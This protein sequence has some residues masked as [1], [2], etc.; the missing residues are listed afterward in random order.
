[1]AALLIKAAAVPFHFWQPDFHTV[2]PTPVSAMLSGIV[3]KLG[4]YGLVRVMT[5]LM[6]PLAGKL[7]P[8]MLWLGIAGIAYGSLG[9]IGTHNLK[10]VLAYSTL[11]QVGFVMVGMGLGSAAAL[12]AAIVFSFNHALAKS[13][14]LML[15]GNV[16][17]RAPI[18]SASF[19]VVTGVGRAVP[20]GG[21]LF[22]IGAMALVGMPPTN[23]FVSKLLLLVSA[24]QHPWL[25]AGLVLLSVLTMIYLFRAYARVWWEP[26]P[27]D[28]KTKPSGDSLLAPTGLIACCLLLGLLPGPLTQLSSRTSAYL[29]EP[30]TYINAVHEFTRAGPRPPHPPPPTGTLPPPIASTLSRDNTP[31]GNP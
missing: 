24:G 6:V 23:G 27:D 1:V 2:S 29:Q 15:A 14:M 25:V 8:L 17:S 18:K 11:A 31:G 22:V 26:L 13:A 28:A 19:S 16:A 10:R 21:W 4:V 7:E 3:V 30:I 5:L 9:A 12:T 20:L